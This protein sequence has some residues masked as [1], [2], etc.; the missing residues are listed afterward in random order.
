MLAGP[1]TQ[2]HLVFTGHCMQQ[3]VCGGLE[4]AAAQAV[5]AQLASMQV[6]AV[7]AG[8][9]RPEGACASW[10]ALQDA[11]RTACDMLVTFAPAD[12]PS[13]APSSPT[14]AGE[15]AVRSQ[16]CWSTNAGHCFHS[17]MILAL[18]MHPDGL[19]ALLDKSCRDC[20]GSRYSPGRG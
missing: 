1:A 6:G 11:V 13:D 19:Q 5:Q 20:R 14:K 18:C 2:L 8:L 3:E 4:G 7:K 15:T 12:A 16:T 9:E 17:M 10:E